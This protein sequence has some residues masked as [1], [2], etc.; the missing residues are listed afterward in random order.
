MSTMSET[1]GDVHYRPTNI[2]KTQMRVYT[3]RPMI[4]FLLAF[5]LAV[6]SKAADRPNVILVMTDDQGWGEVGFHGNDVIKTPNLD[7]FAAEGTELT[8]FYVSPMC[9][10]TRSSLMTGRYHFRT[11]AHDTYIGRSNMKP[12]ETTIA[13]VF[14]DT[15]YRTGIFGKWHLGENFPMRAQDQGFEKVVVHGGGGI[16]QFAD[17][18][19]NTYWLSLIHI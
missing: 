18:P 15:G 11:G 4:V 2:E 8:N 3:L 19:G 9:T 5:G 10:P 12:S 16:G 13:E 6:P 17:F 14:A 7:R 1:S